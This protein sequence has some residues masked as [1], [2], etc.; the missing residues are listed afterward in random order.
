MAI[1]V[2]PLCFTY[3]ALL[4][5]I[6]SQALPDINLVTYSIMVSLVY[7]CDVLDHEHLDKLLVC[8]FLINI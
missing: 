7:G 1:S 4:I 6:S 5:T 8:E 3:W 2:F